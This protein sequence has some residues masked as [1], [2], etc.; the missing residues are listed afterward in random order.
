MV[1]FDRN[2]LDSMLVPVMDIGVMRMRVCQWFVPVSRAMFN[3]WPYRIIM[4]VLVMVL[5]CLMEMLVL[6]VLFQGHPGTKGH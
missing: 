6:M 1:R 5:H 4:N 3:A 2:C